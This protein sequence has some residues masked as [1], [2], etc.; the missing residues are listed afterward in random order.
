MGMSPNG[1]KM[2]QKV[3]NKISL[4]KNITIL[5]GKYKGIDKEI[6]K[7]YVNKEISIG[8]YVLSGSELAIIII[9]DGIIRLLPNI[10]KNKVSALTDSFQ[11][12]LIKKNMSF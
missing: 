8:N 1:K 12:N 6:R 3:I 10:L 9:L 5:C 11:N 2:T 4:R 7:K